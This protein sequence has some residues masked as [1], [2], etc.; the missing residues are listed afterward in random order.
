M[1]F[2]WVSLLSMIGLRGI[3]I[4]IWWLRISDFA[5]FH[6]ILIFFVDA[7]V[8]KKQFFLIYLSPINRN[9]YLRKCYQRKQRRDETT[10]RKSCGM[11]WNWKTPFLYFSRL[12]QSN[13]KKKN[14]LFA[15]FYRH[16]LL[17]PLDFSNYKD[18]ISECSWSEYWLSV[19]I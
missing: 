9:G 16:F 4:K 6:E 19:G 1:T 18:I 15:K 7:Q 8:F 10:C 14:Y 2:P 11:F 17:T 13:Y 3:K 5:G 12:K